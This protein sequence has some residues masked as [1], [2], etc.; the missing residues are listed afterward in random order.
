MDPKLLSRDDF[1]EGVFARDAQVAAQAQAQ[2]HR[3]REAAYYRSN[4]GIQLG[5]KVK[6]YDVFDDSIRRPQRW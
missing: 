3:E 6:S 2:A 5:T 4:P 1:R